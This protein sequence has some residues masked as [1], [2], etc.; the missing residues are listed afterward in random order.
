M[1]VAFHWHRDLFVLER[2]LEW[3]RAWRLRFIPLA[4]IFWHRMDVVRC[5]IAVHDLDFFGGVN[6]DHVRLILTPLLVDR[7]GFWC[8]LH[9]G[10]IKP[11][12]DVNHCI[13]QS[14]IWSDNR[15]LRRRRITRMDLRTARFLRHIDCLLLWSSALKLDSARYC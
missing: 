14:T 2:L 9:L 15:S 11:L 5:G 13:L 10:R 8:R 1:N 3:G 6:G 4:I 7:L 12:R